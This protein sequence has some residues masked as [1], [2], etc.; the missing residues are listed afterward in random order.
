M[1]FVYFALV[2]LPEYHFASSGSTG[3]VFG[4][5]V[6]LTRCR[7]PLFVAAAVAT[8]TATGTAATAT[9]DAHAS[10]QH[11]LLPYLQLNNSCNGC[12]LH[13]GIVN[14]DA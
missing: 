1:H 13:S 14:A 5:V 12:T 7:S 10:V 6:T 8:A 11:P 3:A 2:L 4:V 9:A